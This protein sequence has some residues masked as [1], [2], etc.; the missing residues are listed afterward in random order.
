MDMEIEID[1]NATRAIKLIQSGPSHNSSYK[2]LIEDIKFLMKRCNCSL[3]HTLREGNRDADMLAN[4]GVAQDEHVVILDDPLEDV[5]ALV[6]SNTIGVT[7]DIPHMEMEKGEEHEFEAQDDEYIG[8]GAMGRNHIGPHHDEPP[9][10]KYT[11]G[12]SAATHCRQG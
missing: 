6:I 10:N 1:A 3:G 7:K 8:Y 2:A 11:R 12:C 5:K 9:A 4:M